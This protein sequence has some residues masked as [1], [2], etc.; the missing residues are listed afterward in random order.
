MTIDTIDARPKFLLYFRVFW[1]TMSPTRNISP[2][3]RNVLPPAKG[4]VGRMIPTGSSSSR[5]FFAE[6]TVNC[7]TNTWIMSSMVSREMKA[8]V[9]FHVNSFPM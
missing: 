5:S 6:V 9:V 4:N 8:A 7:V 1:M 2:K 3:P